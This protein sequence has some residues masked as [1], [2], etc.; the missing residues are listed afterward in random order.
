MDSL[1]T[2]QQLKEF[3]IPYLALTSPV[4]NSFIPYS[5][6]V[7]VYRNIVALEYEGNGKHVKSPFAEK[8]NPIT[9]VVTM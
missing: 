5:P 6:L 3:S 9:V 8:F 4:K 7:R 2:K 1:D